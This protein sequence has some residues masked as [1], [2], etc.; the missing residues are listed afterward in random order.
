MDH[1]IPIIIDGLECLV[2][3]RGGQV[4][5]SPLVNTLHTLLKHPYLPNDS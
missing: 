5:H 4:F 3:V 2:R 1:A